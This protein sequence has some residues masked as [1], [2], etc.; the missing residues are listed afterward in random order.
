MRANRL[1]LAAML[2]L[3]SAGTVFA[4]DLSTGTIFVPAGHFATCTATN[5]GTHRIQVTMDVIDS[6]DGSV[7]GPSTCSLD[8][9]KFC[10]QEILATAGADRF[11]FCRVTST[12][13]RIRGVLM[14]ATSGASSETR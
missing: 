7:N 8:P 9:E 2:A 6:L 11:M 3:G 13:K 5:V 12:S 1:A 10:L 4:A 14:D